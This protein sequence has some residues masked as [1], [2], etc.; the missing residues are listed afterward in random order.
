MATDFKE[1]NTLAMHV[2]MLVGA[3]AVLALFMP[4][5]G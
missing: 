4:S 5:I 1:G 3:M 2:V